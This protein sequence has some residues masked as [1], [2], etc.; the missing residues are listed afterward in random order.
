MQ[1]YYEEPEWLK[2]SIYDV[3]EK[4][5]N[6]T[7]FL[8]GIELADF[9]P[10]VNGKSILT[11]MAPDDDAFQ[12]YL[13]ENYGENV[14][15]ENLS[16]SE[17]KKL[18]GFHLMYYAFNKSKLINFRPLEGDEATDEQLNVNAGMFYKHRTKSNDA[19][20][21]EIDTAGNQVSV[22]HLE[23]FLPVFSYRMFKTK[24][25][26][27]KYNYE[28]FYPNSEWK[29]D[30]GFNVSNSPVKEY[31]IIA[32]NGYVYTIGKVLRPLETIY[33]EIRSNDKYSDF[34]SLYDQYEYYE[35]D[36]EL[37]LQYGNGTDLYQHYH[38]SPMANIAC[39]WPVTNY[40]AMATLAFSSYSV[41]APDNNAFRTF[42]NDYWKVGGYESLEEVSPKSIEYLLFNCVYSSSIVFPEEIKKGLI[43]NSYGT[44]INFDVDN[45]PAANRKM[46]VNGSFYGCT[47]L[48]PPAMFGSVTG[49][50][51]QYKKYSYF[52]K[53]LDSSDLIMTL[54]SDQTK[55]MMLYPSDEQM[56]SAG[57]TMVDGVLKFGTANLGSG[58]Q[59]NYVYSHVVGVDG[60]T[61]G[62]R[63][64]PVSGKHVVR[65]LS[66]NL[67]LYWYV[68]NG[69][70]TNSVKYNQL[71]YVSNITKD[72]VYSD[73]Q[74]LTFGEGWTNGK[75]YSYSP[76]LF[77]GTNDNSMYK[78][79]QPLMYNNRNS[80][81]FEFY[82]FVQLLTKADMFDDQYI[83][84]MSESCMMFVPTTKAIRQ[85]ILSGKIPGITT[86]ATNEDE[87]DF[88]STCTVT[89]KEAL[90]YYMLKY[91]I[92]SSS[93]VVSN[94]PYV[95]W[96]ET[97]P[98]GLITLQGYDVIGDNGIVTPYNTKMN[99]VDNGSSLSVNIVG[100]SGS[101]N[102]IEDYDYFPFIFD[103]GC[104]HFI[105]SVL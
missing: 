86:S 82:G 73:F 40:T 95:G 29:D 72:D 5:G 45:V 81:N 9:K 25:I 23:R 18:I 97:T 51:F 88:F 39:E 7:I 83:S 11:V 46:C 24:Q 52:L 37:T 19:I 92:P 89:D 10:M 35:K 4:K 33:Q 26:D 60:I 22:Y 80:E 8:K 99:I 56:N 20:T 104:V 50:A 90:N 91:F 21:L 28:Y 36:D 74:E 30:L 102:V 77:E 76:G 94:Y 101:A 78:E 87:P 42:F 79:F 6:Y 53:M 100:E 103:D 43:E 1:K 84:L 13:K 54:C 63:E 65:T 16:K 67:P 3:L 66:P 69:R 48:T 41:F 58:A 71:L 17:L 57:I 62:H 64:L 98:G 34:L 70:I 12:I 2:G 55:F 32:D 59:Q 49:P 31:E 38:T 85:G 47:H 44:K 27:A 105:D 15:I 75:C 93:A 96:E 14:T 61:G 68:N